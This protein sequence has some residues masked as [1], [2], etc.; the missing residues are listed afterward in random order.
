M[1]QQLLDH[2]PWRNPANLKIL[3]K[4]GLIQSPDSVVHI[5]WLQNQSNRH[6]GSFSNILS[7]GQLKEPA[8]QHTCMYT[9]VCTHTHTPSPWPSQFF[10][11]DRA[12]LQHGGVAIPGA[13]AWGRLTWL[14]LCAEPDQAVKALYSQR[15][16]NPPGKGAVVMLIPS[17]TGMSQFGWITKQTFREN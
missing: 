15:Q 17:E 10:F 11:W 7:P 3:G 9:G 13:Y 6:F 5:L 12:K 1:P 2:F 8:F 16:P 4:A 14:L